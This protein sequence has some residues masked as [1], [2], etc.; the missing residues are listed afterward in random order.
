[1][2][3][4]QDSLLDLVGAIHAAA[5]DPD[6]S[7]WPQAL[8]RLGDA[9][10]GSGVIITDHVLP[11]TIA[12]LACVRVAPEVPDYIMGRLQGPAN[13]LVSG[14]PTLPQQVVL[15][16]DQ[17]IAPDRLHRSPIYAPL[18]S[19]LQQLGLHHLLAAVLDR[20][21]GR[22]LA[23]SL[24]RH[25]ARGPFTA[26]ETSL[27]GRV[28]PHLAGAALV[29]RRLAG[30][31]AAAEAP[32]DALEL[33]DRGV[34]LLDAAGRMAHANAVAANVLA[35][36]DGLAVD[37]AG[38]LVGARSDDTARLRRLIRAAAVAG[39]GA[40]L[41]A[42][43]VATLPR[44]QG[45][46]YVVQV[47]P[48]AGATDLA[49]SV[50]Y[51]A[52]RP[53]A[54]LLL[55]DPDARPAPPE[56]RLRQAYGLTRAEAALAARLVDGLS[57]AEAAGVLGIGRNTAKTQLK[58]VFAK[59]EVERQTA[60]VRRVLADLGGSLAPAAGEHRNGSGSF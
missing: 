28:L 9:L 14:L 20:S 53:E 16:L 22:A 17:V 43:G 41:E 60:L 54:A 58:A 36:R 3:R 32:R 51:L 52:C 29:R 12:D 21:D 23:L 15:A 13:P 59:L 4:H 8:A 55:A 30:L 44:P 37:R 5:A 35:R 24:S 10:G 50:P 2:L 47:L 11:G 48:L 31:L 6:S 38:C 1:M 34:I 46:A 57:L 7:R 45:R 42:G 49:A 39:A 56:H 26:E 40:G 27:L 19:L 33:L 25:A 18:Y